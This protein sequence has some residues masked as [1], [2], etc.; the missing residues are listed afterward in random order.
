VSLK[1]IFIIEDHLIMRE[2]LS[3]LIKREP[4]LEVCGT[5]ET[6]EAALQQLAAVEADLVLL[7]LKLPGMSGFD[8][9]QAL[10][11]RQPDLPCLILSG[12]SEG[13]YVRRAFSVGARG[14]VLKGKPEE[15]LEAI[16]VVGSGGTYLSA[17]LQAKLSG[18]DR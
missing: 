1:Q 3:Y 10:H 7:D 12:Y 13:Y 2:T 5:A 17:A 4:G 16:Q 9:M 14:Y 6:G 11:V 15:I 8:L 18:A